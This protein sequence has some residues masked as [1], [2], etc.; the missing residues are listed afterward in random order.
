MSTFH[1]EQLQTDDLV[2]MAKESAHRQAEAERRIYAT[3]DRMRARA[4][5]LRG[6]SSTRHIAKQQS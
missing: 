6:D 1:T 5:R 4:R 2:S 3:I